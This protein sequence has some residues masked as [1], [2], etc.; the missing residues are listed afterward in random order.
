MTLARYDMGE[1]K[2]KPTGWLKL[3]N[4]YMAELTID[5][6]E[7]GVSKLVP[8]R[9]QLLF[10]EQL[11]K[12]LDEGIHSFT[13][14]KARQ[15]G[16][17]TY[18]LPIDLFW[19]SVYP[20]LQGALVV[21]EEANRDQFRKIIERT[22]SSLPPE[23]RVGYKMHNRNQL[24]LKNGSVLRYIVAGTRKKGTMGV[25]GGY[26]FVHATECSR[27]GDPE[28]WASFMAALAETNPNRLFVYESTAR[29]F[30]LFKDM[31][32]DAKAEPDQRAIFIGWWAKEIY[33]LDRGSKLYNHNFDGVYTK[34]EEERVA[35]VKERYGFEI[36]D[37]QVAW[38]RH[39]TKRLNSEG[40]YIAQEHPWTE[41]EA[42]MMSG[43]M[44]FPNKHLT[45][46][47]HR[48]SRSATSQGVP[49]KGYFYHLGERF[50]TT[51]I[52]QAKTTRQ[53]TLRIWEEPDPAGVYAVGADPAYGDSVADNTWRDRFAIQVL[54]CYADRVV[55]VAE[56]ADDDLAAHQY[57]WVLAHLCGWYRNT[58]VC[59]EI[60]GPGI[61]VYQELKHLKDALQNRPA[62]SRSANPEIGQVFDNW[63]WYLYHR[64]D[65][66][67]GGYMLHF[68]SNN[69][70]KNQIM[71]RM[72]D[73]FMLG[74]LEVNSV[75]LIEEMKEIITKDGWVGAEGRGKDDRTLAFALAHR[76]YDEMIRRELA[77]A[78][79]TYAVE[80]EAAK[81][82]R[83]SNKTPAIMQVIITDFFKTQEQR[84][85][86]LDAQ[87]VDAPLH[88]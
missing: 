14:L 21:D 16:I 39:T 23:F 80:Q 29:G 71:V 11:A 12:G 85:L 17:S 57:A 87:T 68:K 49:F 79:R 2:A 67:G 5:S 24:E 6:K 56:F 88:G 86:N 7:T 10:G 78:G 15:L 61:P 8:Y 52:E 34:E 32:D 45:F 1:K 50:E 73:S 66:L 31:W 72:K 74:M 62:E 13:V 58:K 75:P 64:L 43:R 18:M 59:L 54:R 83:Q 63:S 20:G 27:Y 19:L 48:A 3:L 33:R 26:N 70:L 51:E 40:G 76:A 77:A 53:A 9:S 28:A 81:Q 47:M 84:R 44:F 46:A 35:A 82:R 41:D 38:Y 55:Q 65:S 25:G 37:E 60:N 69:E 22:M 36:T 4:E 30:N 42:F